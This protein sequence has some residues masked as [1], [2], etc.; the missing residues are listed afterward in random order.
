MRMKIWAKKIGQNRKKS[1]VR[2][3]IG[4]VGFLRTRNYS[5]ALSRTV[6]EE[7]AEINEAIPNDIE[8]FTVT[9]FPDINESFESNNDSRQR[10]RVLL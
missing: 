2:K 6:Y 5:S 3:K 10:K 8:E 1:R 4:S 7:H 9:I